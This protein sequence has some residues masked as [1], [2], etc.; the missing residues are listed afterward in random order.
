MRILTK[1]FHLGALKTRPRSSISGSTWVRPT[2]VLITTGKRAIDGAWPASQRG[3][4]GHPDGDGVRAHVG[5]VHLD[6]QAR[7]LGQRDAP[8]A[9]PEPLAQ[10][11]RLDELRPVE[12]ERA[13]VEGRGEVDSRRESE[14]RLGQSR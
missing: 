6:T 12:L 7:P 10:K 13:D 3:M 2:A 5:L 9:L 11:G 14:I 4:S 8:A 1:T